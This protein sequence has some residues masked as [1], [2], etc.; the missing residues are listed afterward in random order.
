M[1]NVNYDDDNKLQFQLQKRAWYEKRKRKVFHKA[2][3]LAG[4]KLECY[5]LANELS[6]YTTLGENIKHV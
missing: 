2:L 1:K 5:D 4:S 3:P 6:P